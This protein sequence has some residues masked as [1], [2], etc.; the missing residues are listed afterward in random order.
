MKFS[1]LQKFAWVFLALALG[2]GTLF[3]QGWRNGNRAFVQNNQ[4]NSCVNLISGLT[5]NQIKAINEL[6]AKHQD[7]M[8]VLREKRRSTTNF[9]EKDLIREEMLEN[10]VN[11]RSAVKKQ[12]ND[13][14]Q[15]EYDKLQLSGNNFR[16][17]RGYGNFQGRG[18]VGSPGNQQGFRGGSR[19]YGNGPAFRQNLNNRNF[20]NCQVPNFRG[21]GFRRQSN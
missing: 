2:T 17:Q 12:F 16:N 19:G 14:Q 9:D 10:V 21:R 11:H 3:A 4:G 1:K 6:E 15:K 13:D 7:E 20:A 18:R 8:A 5:E